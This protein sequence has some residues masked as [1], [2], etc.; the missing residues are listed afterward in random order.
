[1]YGGG[2][3]T[4]IF[5]VFKK[6]RGLACDLEMVSHSDVLSGVIIYIYIAKKVL[7]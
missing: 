1:M 4:D 3:V 7:T 6:N 2:G 5:G